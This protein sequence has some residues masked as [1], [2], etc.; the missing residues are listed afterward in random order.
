MS[1]LPSTLRSI[2]LFHDLTEHDLDEVVNQVAFQVIGNDLTVTIA[3][4]AGQLQL[5]VME[6]V[7]AFNIFQ[8]L[9]MLAQGIKTLAHRCIKGITA[10]LERC[11]ALVE[12]SMG[13]ITALNP[14][15]GY[16]NSTR[17]AKKALETNWGVM[18]LVLEEG[19]LSKEQLEDILTPEKMTQ[20]RG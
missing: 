19:L 7:I 5:N 9:K 13:I 16:E 11:R 6:P 18:E 8:S 1:D 4:E 20:P 12:N 10:N 2:A 3:A 17:I 14:Y 15:I